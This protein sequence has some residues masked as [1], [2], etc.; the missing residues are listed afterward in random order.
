MMQQQILTAQQAISDLR[1]IHDRRGEAS[2]RGRCNCGAEVNWDT[3]IFGRS[4]VN[5]DQ[6][7]WASCERHHSAGGCPAPKDTYMIVA[8][9]AERIGMTIRRL[10]AQSP[11]MVSLMLR[12]SKMA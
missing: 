9:C 2:D 3:P 10:I 6:C 12:E 7:V 5:Q 11:A 1:T 4:G 8:E